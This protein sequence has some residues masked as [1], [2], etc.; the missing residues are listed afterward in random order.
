VPNTPIT[1]DTPVEIYGSTPYSYPSA[2]QK[3]LKRNKNRNY[4][5][6]HREHL[7]RSI[8][9][10]PTLQATPTQTADLRY[11]SQNYWSLRGTLDPDEAD[12]RRRRIIYNTLISN[13]SFNWPSTKEEYK[14][15]YQPYLYEHRKS[16]CDDDYLEEIYGTRHY[17]PDWLAYDD[18]SSCST[19][20][21]ESEFSLTDIY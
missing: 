19:D 1:L 16:E 18:I 17:D 5:Y 4:E 13:N 10:I 20:S 15:Q 6:Q 8:L 3:K 11:K 14:Q 12:E 2:L 9:K 21:T 7:Y